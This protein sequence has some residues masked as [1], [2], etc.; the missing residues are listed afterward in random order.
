MVRAAGDP[1]DHPGPVKDQKTNREGFKKG[2]EAQRR[3]MRVWGY[4]GG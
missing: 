4:S 3:E 2:H 1:S